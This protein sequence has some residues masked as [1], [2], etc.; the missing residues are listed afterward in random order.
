MSKHVFQRAVHNAIYIG[1]PTANLR[2]SDGES[3]YFE[4]SIFSRDLSP[5]PRSRI[6]PNIYE[7]SR[8]LAEKQFVRFIRARLGASLGALRPLSRRDEPAPA[9]RDSSCQPPVF[10]RCCCP[11]CRLSPQGIVDTN[12]VGK[13]E[14]DCYQFDTDTSQRPGGH[15][16]RTSIMGDQ[17]AAREFLIS[18]PPARWQIGV[19]PTHASHACSRK[20]VGN[21]RHRN[22][23]LD[24]RLLFFFFS[25]LWQ[26][27]FTDINFIRII[28]HI[29][30][31]PWTELGCHD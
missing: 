19:Q 13:G 3:K 15:Y 21:A 28:I 20:A 8:R 11:T 10:P 26:L 31:L 24:L 4:T 2:P 27:C 30:G 9:C 23:P 12:C 17:S 18:N 16:V 7:T 5:V 14:R 6:V 1:F 22:G 25:M 29:V